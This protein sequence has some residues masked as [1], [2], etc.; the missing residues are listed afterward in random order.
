MYCPAHAGLG[1]CFMQKQG[2]NI[3]AVRVYVLPRSLIR[4]LQESMLLLCMLLRKTRNSL[5]TCLKAPCQS[6]SIFQQ[7]LDNG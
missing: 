2:R 4:R 5:L 3:Q 6:P 1:I 7:E